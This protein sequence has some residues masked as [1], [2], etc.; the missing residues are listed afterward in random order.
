MRIFVAGGTGATGQVFIPMA[1][2][3]GH[4]LVIHVRPQSKDKT[5]LGADPRARV[6]DL[7]DADALKDA[8]AGN[9]AVLSMIG[10]M[11]ARFGRGDTYASSDI[12]TTADLARGARAAGVPRFFL[13]SSLG[14]GGIGAYL[15]AKGESERI[16]RE[17]G[18]AWTLFRPSALVSPKDLTAATSAHGTR[19]APPAMGGVVSALGH[20]PGL[21]GWALDTK[22]IPIEVVCRAFLRVLAEPADGRIL[23]GR[24]LWALGGGADA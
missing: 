2:A 5:P 10:T 1:T 3:A 6:F 9:G 16:V 7:G 18:L 14:A 17:S 22:P 11:R 21:G 24:E 4:E 8:L 23:Q 15:K 12:G 20:L 13:L 19:S